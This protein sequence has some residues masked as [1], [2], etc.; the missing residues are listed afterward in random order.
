MSARRTAAL[1]TAVAFALVGSLADRSAP[2]GAATA[3]LDPI[4]GV[5]PVGR[6]EGG[7][8]G[9]AVD[10]ARAYLVDAEQRLRVVDVG[11][12]AAPAVI[13]QVDLPTQAEDVAVAGGAAVL[14]LGSSGLCV[15]TVADAARPG[16]PVC[17][18]SDGYAQ[19]VVAAAGFAYAASGSIGLQT[20]RIAD[21]ARPAW[22]HR[23]TYPADDA[24][25]V[26][27]AGGVLYEANGANG[28]YAYDLARPDAPAAFGSLPLSLPARHVS[29][30]GGLAVVGL[31]V[32]GPPEGG[33]LAV[34]DVADPRRPSVKG[35]LGGLGFVRRT[36][37][38]GGGHAVAAAGPGGLTVVD[39]RRPEQ[40][41]A[42]AAYTSPDARDVAAAAGPTGGLIY[43]ADRQT[44]LTILRLTIATPTPTATF[45]PTPTATATP[46][47]TPTRTPTAS[48]TPVRYVVRL[49]RVLANADDTAGGAA[50]A[51]PAAGVRGRSITPTTR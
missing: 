29:A 18:G 24:T 42:V 14:A 37:L 2:T 16:A 50:S 33:G 17:V 4:V 20:A 11:D 48:P 27:L 10:G 41:R 6:L 47:R 26:A 38:A 9:L 34:V 32:F 19:D 39:I 1:S 28:I 21:P 35:T 25:G 15:S 43:L 30:A 31:G 22:V 23:V 46:T 44:G 51:A 5:A 45:T 13:G 8:L 12:P 49:P 7:L 36:A 3:Q 40:P